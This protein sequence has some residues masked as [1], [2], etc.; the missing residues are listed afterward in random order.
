MSRKLESREDALTQ[1]LSEKRSENALVTRILEEREEEFQTLEAQLEEAKETSRAQEECICQFTARVAEL[2]GRPPVD[3]DEVLRLRSLVEENSHVKDELATKA[4]AITKLE[5]E[6]HDKDKAYLVDAKKFSDNID[7]LTKLMH[8]QEL[9]ARARTDQAVDN[10]CRQLRLEMERKHESLRLAEKERSGLDIQ[11]KD[12]M[13]ELSNREQNPCHESAMV[14]SLQESL[15]AAKC[16]ISELSREAEKIHDS[17]E[18]TRKGDATTINKLRAEVM[19]SRK[20][21]AE[22]SDIAVAMKDLFNDC[23]PTADI[24]PKLRESL[25]NPLADRVQQ[26]TTGRMQPDTDDRTPG[27]NGSLNGGSSPKQHATN[28]LPST[29]SSG[30]E[31]CRSENA[32]DRIDGP[33]RTILSS[34]P[35]SDAPQSATETEDAIDQ[36]QARRV[37]VRSPN[38]G[39]VTPVPP[40]VEQEKQRRRE[41]V[42]LKSIIK[43]RPEPSVKTV[44]DS[45]QETG[46]IGGVIPD[47][48]SFLRGPYNRPVAGT[49]SREDRKKSQSE[50]L[51]PTSTDF[52][53][54]DGGD[55]SKGNRVHKRRYSS[56]VQDTTKKARREP[57]DLET[58]AEPLTLPPLQPDTRSGLACGD[59]RRSPDAMGQRGSGT[60]AW[61]GQSSQRGSTRIIITRSSRARGIVPEPLN[62]PNPKGLL[63]SSNKYAR[64]KT[65]GR[66][67]ARGGNKPAPNSGLQTLAS[68]LI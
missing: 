28:H 58:A 5:G 43:P 8:D 53:Q 9:D 46:S 30:E 40:S 60:D 35:L 50:A 29:L 44:Q 19:E 20:K 59:E 56:D 55:T 39:Q 63:D 16:R 15:D 45:S 24:G 31:E 67:R 14:I 7:R 57:S 6:L 27:A 61:P 65:V 54:H 38:N 49:L 48:G 25:E 1:Q 66:Q 51:N 41:I 22:L 32:N 42:Q 68:S 23:I 64:G 4:A 36:E 21:A 17:F 18:A 62:G 2:E 33:E 34:S 26:S 47:Y 3:S 12:T 13:K 52:G 10:A 11:L 37:V